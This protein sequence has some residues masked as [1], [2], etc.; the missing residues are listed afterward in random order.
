M[1]RPRVRADG[2]RFEL[3]TRADDA[4]IRRLL[5]ENPMPGRISI[6][7][8]REPDASLAAAVDGDVHRTIVARHPA[9]G[10][11]MGMGSVSVRDAY[12]NGE[13]TRACYLSQL[14]LDRT[15]RPRAS[16]VIGGYRLLRELHESLDLR[17][18]LTS[19]AA[20]NTVARR[21]LER[22]LPDMPTYR[23]LDAFVTSVIDPRRAS[24][25]RPAGLHIDTCGGD[26]YRISELLGC[27]AR[28]GRR[29]QFT[30][31]WRARDL[32]ERMRSGEI[33]LM[34]ATRQG[35]VVGCVGVWD[36]SAYKQAVIRGYE[37]RLLRW[38]K[39]INAAGR[40][41]N[42]PHLPPV[43]TTLNL[44]YLSHL[45]V[46]EDDPDVF[47][48]LLAAACD[49]SELRSK[50]LADARFVLGMSERHPLLGA[51]SRRFYRFTYRTKLYAVHWEDGRAAAEALEGRLCQPEV[52]LL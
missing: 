13:V 12:I 38:R 9:D 32:I 14:R 50:S 24:L 11:L 44:A 7:L 42:V 5:R 15:C 20:D 47:R 33:R 16:V 49:P 19:I 48:A 23:P 3:A 26:D 30:P 2:V 4:E 36:Q 1:T 51:I 39:W 27:L 40:L 52:A 8:E 10:R 29:H 6:S 31:A 37:P 45:A 34:I 21:F 17:L 43:G 25:R 35:R 28:N 46:D 22:G 18:C 41:F